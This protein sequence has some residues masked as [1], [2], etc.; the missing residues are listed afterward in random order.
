MAGFGAVLLGVAGFCAGFFG[1]MALNPSANQGPLFGILIGGPGG[2]VLGALLGAVLG[3][4][5][6]RAALAR[7]V[8]FYTAAAGVLVILYYALPQPKF[9]GNIVEVQ[10]LACVSPAS[11]KA[12]AFDYWDKR[13]AAAPHAKPRPDWK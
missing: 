1:P 4:A 3:A 2:A 6:V 7:N 13:I 9:R 12:E 5:G 10:V 8:L 11:L